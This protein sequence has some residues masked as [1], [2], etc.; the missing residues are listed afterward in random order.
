[1]LQH[2]VYDYVLYSIG[3]SHFCWCVQL[4]EALYDVLL[5]GGDPKR[6][7]PASR[8]VKG[9]NNATHLL[10]IILDPIG[11]GVLGGVSRKKTSSSIIAVRCPARGHETSEGDRLPVINCY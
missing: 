9:G 5:S 3:N 8:V 2:T 4:G 10:L 11:V 6:R 7:D 1:M